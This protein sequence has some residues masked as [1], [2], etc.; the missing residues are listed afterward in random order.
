MMKIEVAPVSAMA[1]V[2]AIA[3]ALAHSKRCNFVEQY[4]AMTVALSSLI[5]NSPA[6]ESK[7]LYSLGYDEVC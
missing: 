5:D 6:N 2:V 1:Y 3:I 7:W 4:G